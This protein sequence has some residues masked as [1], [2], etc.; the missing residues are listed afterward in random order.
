LKKQETNTCP[1]S[2]IDAIDLWLQMIAD[3]R[4]WFRLLGPHIFSCQM[5]WRCNHR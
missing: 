5:W 3:V 2:N 1:P 4:K